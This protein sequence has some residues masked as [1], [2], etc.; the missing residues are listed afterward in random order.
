MWL[1]AGNEIKSPVKIDKWCTTKLS[2]E[3]PIV[4]NGTAKPNKKGV[5]GWNTTIKK[6]PLTILS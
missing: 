3:P 4:S 6:R 5:K 2:E 1:M